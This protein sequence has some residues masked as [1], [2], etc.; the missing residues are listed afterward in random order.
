MDIVDGYRN[1]NN[2]DFPPK[3][4]DIPF[5]L[6]YTTGKL[7]SVVIP[8]THFCVGRSKE[9]KGYSTTARNWANGQSQCAEM[10]L[11]CWLAAGAGGFASGVLEPNLYLR[12]V[13]PQGRWS[14]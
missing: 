10:D 5:Y 9:V 13:V 12:R 7:V 4:I 14:T 11:A 8:I 6:V 3:Q 1:D 2:G